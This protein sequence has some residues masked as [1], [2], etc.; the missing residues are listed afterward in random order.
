KHHRQELRPGKPVAVLAREGPT[1]LNHQFRHLLGY[2]LHA[3]HVLTLL[4]AEVDADVQTALARMSE[5]AEG[6]AVAMHDLLEAPRVG[7]QVFGRD[8][9]ILHELVRLDVPAGGRA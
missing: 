6:R 3:T 8:T 4:E 1:G 9:C 7:A 5:E 2:R